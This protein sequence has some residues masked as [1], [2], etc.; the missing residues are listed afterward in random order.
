MSKASITRLLLVLILVAEPAELEAKVASIEFSEL[1]KEADLI[2]LGMVKDV[3]TIQGAKLARV[4]VLATYKGEK[5]EEL[6]FLAQ[7]TWTCDISEAQRGE[8]ALLFLSASKDIPRQ[9]MERMLFRSLPTRKKLE[10]GLGPSLFVISDSGRGRMP[11]RMIEGQQYA[12]LWLADVVLPPSVHTVAG[13]EPKYSFIVSARLADLI[14]LIS[15]SKEAR[16]PAEKQGEL[17]MVKSR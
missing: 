12:T 6:F 13:P 2:V 9:G 16:G 5:L 14:M 3:T 7:P 8:T 10:N 15:F 11:L 4:K 17:R 1:A